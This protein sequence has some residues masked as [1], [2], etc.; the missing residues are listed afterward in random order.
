MGFQIIF[1]KLQ[2]KPHAQIF[3]CIDYYLKIDF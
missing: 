1:T 2:W 3:V